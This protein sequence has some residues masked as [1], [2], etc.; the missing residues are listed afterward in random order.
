MKKLIFILL[1]LS[2]SQV[3]AQFTVNVSASE[4]FTPKEVYAYTVNGS[5][6]ILVTKETRKGNSWTI[7]VPQAYT[8]M[9]KLYFPQNNFATNFISENKDVEIKL[10]SVNGKVNDVVYLDEAN[11]VMD[12][13]QSTQRKREDILPAL[14]QIREYYKP[15]AEFGK[16]IDK[17]IAGL[18][19][20]Y[21]FDASKHP[22]VNYYLTNY[23]HF[24]V[25]NPKVKLTGD[26]IIS[27]FS[28]SNSMLETSTLMRPILVEFLQKYNN[29]NPDAEIDKLMEAVN[30]E[31][32][33]GQTVLSEL[34]DVFDSMGMTAMK[35]KYLTKA[36]NLKC[37]INDRLASTI[38]MNKNTEIGAKFPNYNFISPKNTTAKSIYDVKAE[39]KV[40]VFWSSTCSHCE[41]EL[42]Q[43]IPFYNQMKAKNIQIIGL[44]LD[45]DKNSYENKVKNY[46]WISDS[47]LRGWYSTFAELY[48]VKAT[49]TY[50]ILDSNNKIIDKPD[51]VGDVFQY[52]GLK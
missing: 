15:D 17:E 2:A 44:S 14:Y 45:A 6:D 7:K 9:L 1:S 37:T 4:N 51:H 36:K 31:S 49:P 10:V 48:N 26:D 33:R 41:A 18:S 32:P 20:D 19:T 3:F 43:F 29:G 40:I 25:T 38:E 34:I 42:P 52:L 23:N 28:K 50:F 22:F 30:L 39:K 8:G 16:A 5:K 27:F 35:E 24:L 47:E 46:P 11:K 12:E 13:A 21:K